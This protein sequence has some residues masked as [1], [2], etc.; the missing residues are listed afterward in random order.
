MS[1]RVRTRRTGRSDDDAREEV[2][3]MISYSN[4]QTK[5]GFAMSA[6]LR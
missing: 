5:D 6:L 3:L 2:P 1:R 4:P